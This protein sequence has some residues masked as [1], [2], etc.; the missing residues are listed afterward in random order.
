MLE[1]N[2]IVQPQKLR[3]GTPQNIG[4]EAYIYGESLCSQKV[5]VALAEKAAPLCVTPYLYLRC[6][7]KL[8]KFIAGLLEN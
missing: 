2:K 1:P 7:A 8:P 4:L 6:S 5:R 3:S